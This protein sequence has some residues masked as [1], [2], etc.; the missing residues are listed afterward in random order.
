MHNYL[1]NGVEGLR[2]PKRRGNSFAALNT[3]KHLSEIDKLRLTIA[4]QEIEIERLKK[5]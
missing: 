5:G 2:S 3:S 1:D 4:K